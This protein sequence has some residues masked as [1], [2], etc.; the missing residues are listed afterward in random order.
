MHIS[1]QHALTNCQSMAQT[2]AASHG[3]I[4][5]WLAKAFHNWRER[6]AERHELAQMDDRA[7]RDARLNRWEVQQELARPFWRG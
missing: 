6:A 3:G 5:G 2:S 1:A 4:A 7:L